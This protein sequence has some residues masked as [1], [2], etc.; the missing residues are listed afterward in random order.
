MVVLVSLLVLGT[1]GG[2]GGEGSLSVIAA[3]LRGSCNAMDCGEDGE[4]E[5]AQ[6]EEKKEERIE[7][8]KIETK[9]W[10]R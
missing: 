6:D 1:L 7:R 4:L 3:V 2:G 10:G 5:H 8:E 9:S